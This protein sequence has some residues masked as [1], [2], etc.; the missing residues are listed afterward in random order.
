M[1][2][3]NFFSR[4]LSLAGFLLFSNLLSGQELNV[5]LRV[6]TPQIQ[7]TDPQIFRN[8]ENDLNDFLN[9]RTWT[10]LRYE[11][12]ERINVTFQLTIQEELDNNQFTAELAIQATRP[13]FNSD[14][15]TTIL[16][17][18]DRDVKFIYNEGQVI[19]ISPNSYLDNLSALLTFYGY[20][21]IGLDYDTF[22]PLGGEPYFRLAESVVNTVPSSE[23]GNF[24]GWRAGDGNRNRYWITENLMNP[25]VIAFREAIYQ[26]HREG[27]DMCHKNAESC[28]ANILA[29]LQ[30]VEEVHRAYPNSMITQMFTSSKGREI[31]DIFAKG[32][33]EER[34]QVY[35]ILARLDPANINVYRPLRS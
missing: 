19:Q 23:A 17:H 1:T 28:R 21:I 2:T 34:N 9:N 12:S 10:D 16:N 20:L 18:M 30:S 11:P 4:W 6:A 25:R 14:Y 27:L 32:T 8:L 13:V 33:R 3:I 15:E 22:V 24:K 35:Q 31:V 5:Q 7:A 26:Y 29:A